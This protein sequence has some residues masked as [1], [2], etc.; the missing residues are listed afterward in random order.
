MN[1]LVIYPGIVAE[2]DAQYLYKDRQLALVNHFCPKVV[3]GW[4]HMYDTGL[5]MSRDDN[6][7]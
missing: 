3:L 7:A 2:G 5:R 1:H 4:P 6:L